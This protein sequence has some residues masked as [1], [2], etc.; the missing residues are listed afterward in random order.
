MQVGT[1][2]NILTQTI[3]SPFASTLPS[4][5]SSMYTNRQAQDNSPIF[6]PRVAK[7]HALHDLP[8]HDLPNHALHDHM[9]DDDPLSSSQSL[10]GQANWVVGGFIS[11]RTGGVDGERQDQISF[12][13]YLGA[14]KEG[15]RRK[16]GQ[17]QPSAAPEIANGVDTGAV[18][19]VSVLRIYTFI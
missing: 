14:G 6:A 17:G 16:T 5:T 7:R 9:E 4:D 19:E 11:S 2:Q 18:W 8:N 3:V 12:E 1:A 10:T 15:G 13:D